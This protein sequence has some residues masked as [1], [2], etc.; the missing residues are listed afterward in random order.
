MNKV[1]NEYTKDFVDKLKS[2]DEY[3]AYSTQLETLKHFPE[4]LEKIN[5]YRQ[6]NFLIQTQYE[7]EELYDKMEEFAERNERLLENPRVSDFLH[8]EAGLC[9]LIQ[10]VNMQITEGLNFQ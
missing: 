1:A 5:A 10:D 4:L 6:E 2:T 9:R 3:I 7:G 8:A